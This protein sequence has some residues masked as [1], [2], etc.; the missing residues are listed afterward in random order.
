MLMWNRN[1]WFWFHF[2][3]SIKQIIA[4]I[5][6]YFWA[7]KS[8]SKKSAVILWAYMEHAVIEH[9]PVK[10]NNSSSLKKKNLKLPRPSLFKS[11]LY[12][13]TFTNCGLPDKMYWKPERTVRR[14]LVT[15]EPPS[16]VHLIPIKARMA[17]K[18]PRQ[19]EEIIRPRH[20]WI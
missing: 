3:S 16:F 1:A 8:G 18:N 15:S 12:T 19:T 17:P 13:D 9:R 10:R 20:T 5:N 11:V 14:A 4:S 2:I 7:T 6:A